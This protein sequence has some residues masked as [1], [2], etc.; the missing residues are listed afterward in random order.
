MNR[1]GFAALAALLFLSM[2]CSGIKDG[3]YTFHIL[4]TNDVHGAYFD[5]TYTSGHTRPSL[6]AVSAFADSVRSAAGRER[7][8]LLD[9]GDCLQGDNASY[10]FNYVDTSSI[11]IY[12]RMADYMGYDAV[13]VGNHD[14]EA[15]HPV[16][17][18]IRRQMKTPFLASNALRESDRK[19]YFLDY[20]TF[21]RCGVKFA[22]LGYTNPNIKKWLSEKQWKGMYFETLVPFVQQ[23]VNLVREKEKPDV[24]IVVAHTGT[25]AGDGS[26]MENC[27]ADLFKTLEGVDLVVCAHDHRQEVLNG[28]GICMLNAGSRC[29]YVGVCD[30]TLTFKSG[31]CV[32]KKVSGRLAKVDKTKTDEKMREMFREDYEKVKAFTVKEIGTLTSNI[33]TNLSFKGQSDYLNLIHTVCLTASPAEISFAAPLTYN[34]IVKSG[35]LVYNDLFTVYPYENTLMVV[36]MTGKEIRNYLEYSYDTWI[37]SVPVTGKGGHVLKIRNREDK[38]NGGKRWSFVNAS[39]NFD[40]AGGINYTVDVTRPYGKRIEILSMADGRPFSD[41]GWYNVAMTSYRANGGG[42]ILKLGAGIEPETMESRIVSM[43]CEIR[44][45]VYEYIRDNGV[46]NPAVFGDKSKVGE[47]SF[48]PESVAE[49]LLN[50]D[51]RLLFPSL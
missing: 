9:G 33:R 11:H 38:R 3:E 45:M 12:A 34:G 20:V 32:G 36:K 4:T 30:L 24:V 21:E 17:D 25:G 19:P 46:V 13:A 31:E 7:V 39:F 1:F 6:L 23:D 8:I 10:F 48:I 41:D 27:G 42:D 49:P 18:R 5:S 35:T 2:S 51:F 44:E 22:V 47:W 15:G 16:Y 37:N 26:D 28:E 50:K 40:S 29:N 43:S 14:I